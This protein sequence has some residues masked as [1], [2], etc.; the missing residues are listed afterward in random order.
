MYIY[1]RESEIPAFN[2]VVSILD[3]EV[4]KNQQFNQICGNLGSALNV[5]V[6]ITQSGIFLSVQE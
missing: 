6:N 2:L 1:F 3:R 5:W 4:G